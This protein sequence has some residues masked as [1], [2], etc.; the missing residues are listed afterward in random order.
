MKLVIFAG[1]TGTRLWPLSRKNYPKQFIK[2][3]NGKSTL[4][5]AVE[6]V[7]DKFGIDNIIISTNEKYV[8]LVKDVIPDIPVGNIVGEPEKRDVA[9]AVGLNLIRLKKQGYSGPVAIL[10]ADHLIGNTDGYLKLLEKSRDYVLQNPNK[11]VFVGEKPRFADNNIGWINIGDQVGDDG[12]YSYKSWKY[13]PGYEEC[14]EMYKSNKWVWNTGY[15]VEDLNFSLSLFQKFQPEMYAGLME[16][17]NAL[18]TVE[19][20]S[21]TKKVYPT[22]PKISHDNAISEKVDP[23]SA[24]VFLADISFSDPGTLYVLKKTMVA[25]EDSNYEYG[26]TKAY[27]TTDTMLFNMEGE[28]L[29]AGIGL[30]GMVVVN[31]KDVILIVPKEKVMDVSKFVEDLS[32]NPDFIKYI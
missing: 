30:R 20:A 16:I 23:K 1:G 22:L 28:K 13:K 9:P 21:I 2:M 27:N 3:F 6:R 19:E 10:W 18:G 26:K 25:S 31:T 17:Y 14:V 24:V 29:L 5:L 11:I 7:R 8:S 32:E 15:I 4:Q 12:F